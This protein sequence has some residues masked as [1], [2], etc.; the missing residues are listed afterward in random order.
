[1]TVTR[2]AR[3]YT[4]RD[5]H[6]GRFAQRHFIRGRAGREGFR[7]RELARRPASRTQDDHRAED[8]VHDPQE[9][10]LDQSGHVHAAIEFCESAAPEGQVVQ[11]RKRPPEP[12]RTFPGSGFTQLAPRRST[13]TVRMTSAA[14][15]PSTLLPCHWA[16]MLVGQWSDRPDRTSFRLG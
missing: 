8:A 4:P 5:G 12:R 10:L 11:E 13:V 16:L 1:M 3:R 9:V 15:C 6:E 2:R 14:A 7:V